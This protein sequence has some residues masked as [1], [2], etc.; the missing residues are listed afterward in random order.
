MKINI[1]D[2]YVSVFDNTFAKTG[3][4]ETLCAFLFADHAA[5]VEAVRNEQDPQRQKALKLSLP[6][7]TIS[8]VFSRRDREHLEQYSGLLCIDIDG[9]DNPTLTGQ[10]EQVKNKLAGMPFIGFV[11]LSVR[12][13]GL[14]AIMPIS[15]PTRHREHYEAVRRELAGEGITIDRQC[16]DIT[17]LR[18]ASHDPCPIIKTSCEVYTRMVEATPTP[19]RQRPPMEYRRHNGGSTEEKVH[20]LVCRIEAEHLNLTENYDEWVRIG[21]ALADMGEAGREYY[22]ALSA[23]SD[24]YTPAECDRKF[25]RLL[26]TPSTIHIGTFFH[27][28]QDWGL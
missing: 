15:D 28:C 6:C 19:A 25:T 8:G 27:V 1:F 20:D 4:T 12:A 14:F 5:Q 3:R 11:S 26:N 24:K 2:K 22:H 18:I 16:S 21:F 7:A 17:R 13:N 10:W 9:N 23:L